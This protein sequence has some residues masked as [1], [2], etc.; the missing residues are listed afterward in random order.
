MEAETHFFFLAWPK[1]PLVYGMTIGEYANMINEENV[2]WR[3]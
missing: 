1:I 2:A 3:K